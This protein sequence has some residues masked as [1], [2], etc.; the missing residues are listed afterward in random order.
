MEFILC[1]S[2]TM[3]HASRTGV[4]PSQA[5][6]SI[7]RRSV[8]DRVPQEARLPDRLILF[9]LRCGFSYDAAPTFTITSRP[10][11]HRVRIATEKSQ[12]LSDTI[13]PTAPQ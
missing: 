9:S 13:Q 4:V 8:T 1:L 6:V 12:D 3:R 11:M 5:S 7:S 10:S 2:C